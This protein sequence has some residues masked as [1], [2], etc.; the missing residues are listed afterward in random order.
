MWTMGAF[1]SGAAD[2][3]S[4]AAELMLKRRLFLN[5]E[6]R[7]L[8]VKMTCRSSG[9][10]QIPHELHDLPSHGLRRARS[11]MPFII[12]AIA[13]FKKGDIMR[14]HSRK[15]GTGNPSQRSHLSYTVARWFLPLYVVGAALA[16]II[17]IL[18]FS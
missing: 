9:N 5:R 17:S 6:S 11:A 3:P 18:F 15:F 1:D 8:S 14:Q 12:V 13:A 2:R 4:L 16:S 10:N 7:A